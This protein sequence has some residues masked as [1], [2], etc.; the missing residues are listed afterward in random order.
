[1]I[2]YLISVLFFC[3][4]ESEHLRVR[5][6]VVFPGEQAELTPSEKIIVAS[7]ADDSPVSE[8]TYLMWL[9]QHI[10]VTIETNKSEKP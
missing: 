1:M 7:A 10:S 8:C 6:L 2:T 9:K 3:F 4:Q 5:V